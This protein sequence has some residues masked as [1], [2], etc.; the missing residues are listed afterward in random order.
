[1]VEIRNRT[2]RVV[3]DEKPV[4]GRCGNTIVGVVPRVR[5]VDGKPLCRDC[6]FELDQIVRKPTGRIVVEETRTAPTREETIQRTILWGALVAI[7]LILVWRFMAIAPLIQP[8]RPLRN[9]TYETDHLTDLCIEQLWKLSKKLQENSLP[10]SF[11]LCPESGRSYLLL[12]EEDDI[13][14]H[15]PTPGEHGLTHLSV[16]LRSPVPLAVSGGQ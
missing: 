10:E 7:I 5:E 1:M 15:C 9:G 13:V 14:I 12:Q 2:E 16:S 4:C 3:Y 11:P 6:I 8:E